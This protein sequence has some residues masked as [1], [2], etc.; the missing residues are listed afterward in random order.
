MHNCEKIGAEQTNIILH[1]KLENIT[2]R[3]GTFTHQELIKNINKGTS[4]SHDQPVAKLRYNNCAT[5]KPSLHRVVLA[6]QEIYGNQA[7][8]GTKLHFHRP[9]FA[10]SLQSKSIGSAQVYSIFFL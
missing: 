10:F 5:E 6:L 3:H 4:L 2:R 8:T 9:T 1:V 7:F